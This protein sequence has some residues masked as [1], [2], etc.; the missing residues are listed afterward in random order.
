MEENKTSITDKD[1]FLTTARRR[2]KYAKD[3]WD[4]NFERM[5]EDVEF[6]HGENQ[7]DE[8]IRESRGDRPC[9]TFNKLAAIIDQIV[10]DQR[11][12]RPSIHVFPAQG[13]IEGAD[14]KTQNQAGTKDYSLAEVYEGIIRNI[15]Y[16]SNADVAYDTGFEHCAGWGLGYFRILTAYADDHTFDQD[17]QIKRVRNYKSVLLDP[18][19]QEADGSDAGYGFIFSKIHKDDFEKKYPGKQQASVD[20]SNDQY[21][22]WADGDFIFVAEYYYLED[23]VFTLSLLS[24]GR[25]VDGEKL[26]PI[27]DELAEAGVT[28]TRTRKVH[29]KKCMWAKIS[30]DEVLDERETLFNYIPIIPV[31]GKELVVDGTPYYRGA[32]RHSKDAQRMYNY[33]RSADIERT[34]LIPKVP[35]II[36]DRQV[37]DYQTQ[38]E[39]ANT[40]NYA[41]LTYKHIDGVPMPQRQ[42]PVSTNPGEQV[43]SMQASDDIKATSGMHDASM[44]AQG[45]ETSGKAIL[46]R[47]RE[48]DVGSFAFSDNMVR[49]IRHA[50]RILINAIPKLYD[51]ERL[52]R[53]RFPDDSEDFVRINESII[54]DE[55]GKTVIINDL[56][57]GKFDLVVKAGPSYS[58]QRMEA[59]DSMTQILQAAPDLWSVIGDLVAKNMEWPGADEF[60]KRLKKTIPPEILDEEPEEQDEERLPTPEEV[61]QI[62]AQGVEQGVEEQL[63]S[64]ENAAKM[65]DSEAKMAKAEA[66]KAAAVAKMAE[67]EQ[68]LQGIDDEGLRDKVADLLAEFIA[69]QHAPDN[70]LQ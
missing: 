36:A 54:D 68:G 2:A 3:A 50:G 56:S 51:T 25:V 9:L 60:A 1:E 21:E 29:G 66:D 58:T 28:V 26:E 31:L 44:G 27:V 41:Y 48:G 20:I 17:F 8:E 6:I 43:Q 40:I 22:I 15:E 61:Q 67:I 12:M 13:D 34:A 62:I 19:F 63:S 59:L 30:A 14:A 52:I 64:G 24:D 57:V 53:L 4:V 5:D 35:Y 65:A 37:E 18:D 16:S 70:G 49:S 11:Q 39:Q 23:H 69:S 32:I 42:A 47:Q 10:G 7:W 38:W 45:N 55:T 46:A 33:S